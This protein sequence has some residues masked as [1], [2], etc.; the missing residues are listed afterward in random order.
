MPPDTSIRRIAITGVGIVAPGVLGAEAFAERLESGESFLSE[1]TRFDTADLRS[2]RAGLIHE[3]SAKGFIPPM[4]MRRMNYLSR[5][6]LVAAKLALQDLSSQERPLSDDGDDIGVAIG[7]MFGPVQTSV[8]YLLEYVEKGAALAPPQL[9]AESVA[10]APGSHIAIEYGF[11]GFNLTFTQRESSVLA[12]AMFASG[13]ILKGSIQGAVVGGVEEI[14]EITFSVLDRI[15][16]LATAD[17]HA[18]EARPFDRDRRG[19]VVGEGSAMFVF[20]NE[21]RAAS[22]HR[23]VYA[24]LTGFGI[25]RDLSASLS[26]WGSDATGVARAMRGAMEDAGVKS[27][28]IDAVWASA[29][30]SIAGDRVEARAIREVFGH[31]IPPVVA[32]KSSFGEY[33]AAG[34][35]HFGSAVMALNRQLLP[36]TPGYRSSEAGLELPVNVSPRAHSID[37]ILV[38]SL[39]AGGGIISAILESAGR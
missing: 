34:G 16:A 12:A 1:I 28:E 10:N 20:E 14:N 26:N 17:D 8:E 11:R 37:R 2:H 23:R 39:S 4:K 18:E 25:A 21:P 5:M 15:R 27:E 35:L 22:L 19:I 32:T 6:G 33:A 38:N 30:G 24:Y 36:G 13:Q 7:T 31:K 9:F 3:F 29:N